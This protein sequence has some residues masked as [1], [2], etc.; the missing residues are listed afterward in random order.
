MNAMKEIE[1]KKAGKWILLMLVGWLISGVMWGAL[2]T[3]LWFPDT[4]E[5]GDVLHREVGEALQNIDIDFENKT[6]REMKEWA[7]NESE[8]W[9]DKEMEAGRIKVDI[10]PKQVKWEI[11]W[12]VINCCSWFVT[13]AYLW[14]V[15]LSKYNQVLVAAHFLPFE[16]SRTEDFPPG[17]LVTELITIF[18]VVAIV[19][20]MRK[21]NK[22]VLNA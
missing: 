7:E 20:L 19:F 8:E 10:E 6:E 13:C 11:W 1:G 4:Q 17:N 2:Y 9:L 12:P 18:L 16:L 21:R 15:G 3:Y 22:S 5:L 14:V